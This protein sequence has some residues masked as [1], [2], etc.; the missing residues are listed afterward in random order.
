MMKQM[1]CRIGIRCSSAQPGA[2]WLLIV[3]LLSAVPTI[4]AGIN[5]WTSVLPPWHEI[6]QFVLD[7]T[8]SN[9]M[10]ALDGYDPL[11]FIRT[12][13]DGTTWTEA[14]MTD[15]PEFA[16]KSIDG[17]Q[18]EPFVMYCSGVYRAYSPDQTFRVYKSEDRSESWEL[19]FES[20][21]GWV[22]FERIA[23]SPFDSRFLYA[24]VWDD[25]SLNLYQSMDGGFHWE[26]GFPGFAPGRFAFSRSN[27]GF[28]FTIGHYDDVMTPIR[29]EDQGETWTVLPACYSWQ[30]NDLDVSQQD[31][32]LIYTTGG[33]K[34]LDGGKT[35]EAFS[36]YRG[37]A[38]HVDPR[39]SK[40]IIYKQGMTG[41]SPDGHIYSTVNGGETWDIVMDGLWDVYN[42][43]FKY[44][45]DRPDEVY[46]NNGGMMKSTDSGA[47]WI[48]LTPCIT[49]DYEVGT[50]K[51]SVIA[52]P[53][54][55]NELLLCVAGIGVFRSFDTG[56]TWLPSSTGLSDY[57][58]KNYVNVHDIPLVLD[59]FDYNRVLVNSPANTFRSYDRGLTWLRSSV[60]FNRLVPSNSVPGRVF[61]I[62]ITEDSEFKIRTLWYSDDFGA[63]WTELPVPTHQAMWDVKD[64][65]EDPDTLYVIAALP[66]AVE[67]VLYISHDFSRSW[68][69]IPAENLYHTYGAGDYNS[70][71]LLDP[72]NPGWMYIGGEDLLRSKD[73]GTTWQM[74]IDYKESR[75]FSEIVIDPSNSAI[76]YCRSPDSG[77]A[78]YHRRSVDYG[79]TWSDRGMDFNGP[80]FIRN[81]PETLICQIG[82]PSVMTLD[83]QN[84]QLWLS[85]YLTTY[86]EAG[87]GGELWIGAVAIDQDI[88]DWVTSVELM[89][90]ESP[91][92]MKLF[93]DGEN[94]SDS[95]DHTLFYSSI[96][97]SNPKRGAYSLSMQAKDRFAN[98]SKPWP[99]LRGKRSTNRIL[100]IAAHPWQDSRQEVRDGHESNRNPIIGESEVLA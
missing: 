17:T 58:F 51:F 98:S 77:S 96:P 91:L 57:E 31:T 25:Q 43:R 54:T 34:S 28:V 50:E 1:Q 87:Q 95:G 83:T 75:D 84:P 46:L 71:L 80:G 2:V 39:D 70:T 26:N 18:G 61:G 20:P 56:L 8:L 85:G 16:P 53:D 89:I 6:K 72:N 29:S 63:N 69:M 42:E 76:L 30:A 97:V 92:G 22:K 12:T 37:I 59:N 62:K 68:E 3:F 93:W 40:R 78:Y 14:R 23:V 79:R 88:N 35:W 52:F 32:N 48:A 64:E 90:G 21:T 86:L 100:R 82:N 74:V 36:S 55:P 11:S 45:A 7:P 5:E 73:Y 9:R 27:P 65:Y 60:D 33:R 10:Y 24:F 19:V 81:Q 49:P 66:T 4:H 99:K 44:R 13:D 15:D 67:M 47:T 94:P 41:V 38:I